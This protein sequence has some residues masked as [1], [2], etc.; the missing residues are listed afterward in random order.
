MMS[1]AARNQ[2]Q[3]KAIDIG[4]QGVQANIMKDQP[5]TTKKAYE[6]KPVV[7]KQDNDLNL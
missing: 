3:V 6:K 7:F 1:R 5:K 2:K 4:I